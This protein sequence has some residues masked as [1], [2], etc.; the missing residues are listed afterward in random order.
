MYYFITFLFL[1]RILRKRWKKSSPYSRVSARYVQPYV[2]FITV[3]FWPR[4]ARPAPARAHH[5]FMQ[6]VRAIAPSPL[7]SIHVKIRAKRREKN[8][9]VSLLKIHTSSNL[10]MFYN[11]VNS[12]DMPILKVFRI[13][14]HQ[15]SESGS[16]L[17]WLPGFVS[18]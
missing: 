13:S 10:D 9:Q 8:R 11:T 4:S 1:N 5:P 18:E 2:I 16:A 15:R 3:G 12:F 14:Q 7:Y 6:M 17:I